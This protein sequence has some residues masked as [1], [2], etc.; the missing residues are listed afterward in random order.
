MRKIFLVLGVV[1]AICG[2]EQAY[3]QSL[4]LTLDE[5]VAIA[6]DENPTMQVAELEIERYDY[7]LGATRGNLLPQLSITGDYSYAAKA[8]QMSSS[9][10]LSSDGTH[11]VTATA[12]LGL[13]LYAP[14]VYA[15]LKMNRI[16]VAEAVESARSSKIDL[17][18]AVK[19]AF[20]NT[21][22]AQESLDVLEQSSET[23]KEVVDDTQVKFNNG[24]VSEYDLLTAQVQYNNLQPSII[25]T[26]N[27]IE[28]AKLM[29][30]MYLSIPEDVELSVVG[31][32]SAMREQVF[33][34]D[35]NLSLDVDNNSTIRTLDI[36][37]D[38]LAQQLKLNKTSHQP[39]LTAFVS[40]MYTGSQQ[41]TFG[42]DYTTGSFTAGSLIYYDQFPVYAGLSLNIPIFAGL[43]TIN[44]SRQIRN[45]QQQLDIQRDYARQGVILEAQSAVN[46]LLA[47]RERMY[48]EQ[49]TIA[50][51]QKAYDIS[52]VRYDAETGTI[53]ELNSAQLLLTQSELNYSQAIYD[54]LVAKA[55]Y[56]K[57]IGVEY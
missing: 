38:L 49:T 11:S 1:M 37:A 50:Q 46:N 14:A 57:V 25:Q 27:S 44:Q 47:A 39:T 35:D 3:S 48:A 12:N 42:I 6:L 43:T 52:Q 24:L 54:F 8:Q 9:M 36:Q 40:A 23:S 28:L 5:A 30:K 32:L 7:V 21:L 55:E 17:V 18:A 22:L 10:Q 29:L 34:G 15:T 4:N 53:L 26:R 45:Q 51:A 16:Q 56:D 41:P 2:V 31:S 13:A 19:S 20:Y 33:E